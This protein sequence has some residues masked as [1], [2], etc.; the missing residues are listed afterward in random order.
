[1]FLTLSRKFLHI[2]FVILL[3]GLSFAQDD[4]LYDHGLDEKKWNELRDNIRY[5]NQPEGAGR[6]WTYEN[7]KDYETAKRERGGG[8]GGSGTGDGGTGRGD[9]GSYD[10]GNSRP[11]EYQEYEEPATS[12][13]SGSFSGLGSLGYVLLALFVVLIAFLIYYLFVNREKDG[14]NVV[15]INLEET[16]PLEIPLTELERMLQEAIARGDYRGAVRIYF[17]FIIRGLSEKNWIRWEKEKTNFQYLRE[18]NGRN[19][20]RDFNQSVSYFEIIW[21]GKREIDK[22]T[23]DQIKPDFTKF[24][25]KLGV[26]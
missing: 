23:F 11:E 17:I 13:P 15:P 3:S 26:K 14:K 18:M 22:N 12:N 16:A 7:Q 10:G 9:G 4:D 19:E 21:Y 24:L 5:E 8:G 25:D 2:A 20:Y 6:E 1:M